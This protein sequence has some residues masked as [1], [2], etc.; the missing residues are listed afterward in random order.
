VALYDAMTRFHTL[1]QVRETLRREQPDAVFVSCITPRLWMALEVCRVAKEEAPDRSPVLGNNHP[2]SCF[3]DFADAPG[4]GLIVRSEGEAT[5][6]E[7][8]Q[9]WQAGNAFWR[10]AWHCLCKASRGGDAARLLHQR[11]GRLEP[12]WNLV[13]WREYNYR[14]KPGSTLAVFFLARLQATLSFCSQRLFWQG[15]LAAFHRALC[16]PTGDAADCYGVDVAMMPMK[17]PR[18]TPRVGTHS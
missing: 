18:S 1:E 14:V 5:A 6:V 13:P 11:L 3:R 8:L 4:G 16:G 7:L 15:V 10:G 12:A 9:A 2:A 17:F